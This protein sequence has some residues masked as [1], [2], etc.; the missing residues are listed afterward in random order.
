MA[1]NEMK[2]KI[3]SNNISEILNLLSAKIK[4]EVNKVSGNK[5]V[6]DNNEDITLNEEIRFRIY[7]LEKKIDEAGLIV[8]VVENLDAT[9]VSKESKFNII[10]SNKD[11]CFVKIDLFKYREDMLTYGTSEESI[12]ED[13]LMQING[14]STHDLKKLYSVIAEYLSYLCYFKE[15]QV[16]EFKDIGWST[17]DGE[18]IFK[19][20]VIYSINKTGKKEYLDEENINM[21]LFDRKIISRNIDDEYENLIPKFDFRKE[22]VL[23][24]YNWLLG[25]ISVWEHNASL[26]EEGKANRPYNSLILSAACTG[27]IR[28]LVSKTKESNININIVGERASG[29][30]TICHFAMSLFGNP[31]VLE[32]SFSDS[33]EAAEIIRAKRPVMPYILDE[34]MLR[35]EGESDH[36]KHRKILMSIFREYEGKVKERMAGTGKELSGKRTYSPII[37]SSVESMMDMLILNERDLGQYRRFIELEIKPEDLFESG[38][39]AQKIEKLALEEYGYGIELIVKYILELGKDNLNDLHE[40]VLDFVNKKL[41]ER[42]CTEKNK[43]NANITGLKSSALRFSLIITTLVV[44]ERAFKAFFVDNEAELRGYLPQDN[45]LNNILASIKDPESAGYSILNNFYGV[46]NILIDNLV[47]KMNRVNLKI[48]AYSNAMKFIAKHKKLFAKNPEGLKNNPLNYLGYMIEDNEIEIGFKYKKG[49]EWIICWGDL[50]KTDE[51]ILK[52]VEKVNN[53]NA[54]NSELMLEAL[55]EFAPCIDARNSFESVIMT[56][57]K[58]HFVYIPQFK[59]GAKGNGTKI[60]LSSNKINVED[61]VDSDK[62][63]TKKQKKGS[64]TKEKKSDNSQKGYVTE[65][66]K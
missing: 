23:H 43:G 29:K 40:Q 60:V 41:E 35:I 7:D 5:F 6:Y 3:D 55:R 9:D 20:N 59:L 25:L 66:K 4:D 16:K 36:N 28:P 45:S 39:M 10:I 54:N 56:K 63:E 31:E 22:K 42:E 14:V 48:E 65:D 47:D 12:I 15:F 18:P 53:Y 21:Y 32:G 13:A 61:F 24:V 57:D 1:T 2:S 17:Y 8:E 11:G 58:G 46:L 19:Y 33:E 62:E 38:E 64:D 52:Y 50:N 51:D 37:S 44:V 49:Y 34:R 26:V 27:L 30:S